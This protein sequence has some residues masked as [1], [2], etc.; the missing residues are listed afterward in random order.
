[1]PPHTQAKFFGFYTVA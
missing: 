1:M